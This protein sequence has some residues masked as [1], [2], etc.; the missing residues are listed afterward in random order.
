MSVWSTQAND[1]LCALSGRVPAMSD[2]SWNPAAGRSYT[3]YQS[4]VESTSAILAALLGRPPP[5]PP[6]PALPA[7]PLPKAPLEGFV[8][9]AGECRDKNGADGTR[10]ECNGKI[11]I[12]DC[13]AMCTTQ[14]EKCDAYDWG[15]SGA[16][17]GIWGRTF[18]PADN[19]T[20]A[21]GHRWTW[22]TGPDASKELPACRAVASANI[23]YHRDSLD[24]T[25]PAG[26]VA[27]PVGCL[28]GCT[29]SQCFKG[30]I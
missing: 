16:W 8:G 9:H 10:L 30:G 23:C 6:G 27:A 29:T 14:G 1:T 3:D 18:T 11:T 28:S 17:C 26:E 2:K 25:P 22:A 13:E 15:E 21:S 24:C 7:P 20:S 12:N 5:A 19:T 4:R